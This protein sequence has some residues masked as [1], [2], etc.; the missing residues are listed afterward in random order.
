MSNAGVRK[1]GPGPK[2]CTVKSALTALPYLEREPPFP[3]HGALSSPISGCNATL[4][5]FATASSYAASEIRGPASAGAPPKSRP[6]WPTRQSRRERRSIGGRR[7]DRYPVCRVL[8]GCYCRHHFAFHRLAR[9]PQYGMARVRD[10]RTRV[11]GGHLPLAIARSRENRPTFEAPAHTSSFGRWCASMR[12]Q[13]GASGVAAGPS[14]N[15]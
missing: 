2:G 10:G 15:A 8:S 7:V 1:N 5:I 14:A 4:S 11:S 12:A 9:R 6:A 13:P 3:A